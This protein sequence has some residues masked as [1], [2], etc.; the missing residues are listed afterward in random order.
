LAVASGIVAA[1]ISS[2]YFFG[3]SL[4]DTGNVYN[5]TVALNIATF[6]IIPVMPASP[7]YFAGRYSN[8]PLWSEVAASRLGHA[9]D[10]APAGMSL[11][12][13]GQM[14]GTGRNYAIAG[15]RTG[16]GGA[17]GD[18]DGLVPTGVTTQVSY[19]LSRFAPD[20]SAMYFMQG[21]GNDLRSAAALTDTAALYQ[22]GINA[23]TSLAYA[24]YVLYLSGARHLTMLNAPNVGLIPESFA[25]GRTQSGALASMVFNY[26][27]NQYALALAQLPGMELI[28]VDVFSLYNELV[29]DTFTGGHQYGFTSMTPCINNQALCDTTL[30]FDDIHPTRRVHSILGSRV[31]D[32][33]LGITQSS[34]LQTQTLAFN[35][36]STPEPSSFLLVGTAGMACMMLRRRRRS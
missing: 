26:T 29:T 28:Y 21:G 3:D 23:A 25:N 10:A 19:Y 14:P 30:F 32:Q 35:G 18:L 20:P 7:P 31:A 36:V 5:T 22:A 17:L 16:T 9:Q 2:L 12:V 4:T 27:L 1:P 13:F 6:G 11:G 24:S 8:G 15:A 34:T 33:I